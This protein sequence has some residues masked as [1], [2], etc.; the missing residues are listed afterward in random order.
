[1]PSNAYNDYIETVYESIVSVLHNSAIMFIPRLK[2]TTL[3]PWWSDIL[4]KLK[5]KALDSHILWEA[6]GR[7]R[8][9]LIFDVRNRDKLNYKAEIR[10]A[11]R[12]TESSISNELYENL[13]HKDST[14]FWKT[15]NSKVNTNKAEIKIEGGGP[16]ADVAQKFSAFFQ[17]A[18]TPN[19]SE[20]N[21]MKLD[22][23]NTKLENYMGDF[24]S[25]T[26]NVALNAEFIA[27]AV[28]KLESGKAP[29]HDGLMLEHL[30]NS[31]PVIYSLLAMLFRFIMLTNYIPTSF[32]RGIMIPLPKEENVRGAHKIEN[33]RGITL[34]PIISKVF[35]HCLI[36]MF[37]KYLYSCDNQFGFKTKVGCAHA[38]YIMREVV[39]YYVKNDSMINLC[40]IDVSKAFDILYQP[41]LFLKLMK[42]HVLVAFIRL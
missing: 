28:C 42:R 21:Q 19:S 26:D 13:C 22:E 8:S 38:I 17:K 37:G 34:S 40:L 24:I 4:N 1:V 27:L 36:E 7:P 11:K 14:A 6:C 29:G 31:H 12:S 30:T 16:D 10:R 5:A 33:F 23:L 9:G 3:K 25:L 2:Q 32:G 15:W 18:C 41:V 35:E 20:F 39:D